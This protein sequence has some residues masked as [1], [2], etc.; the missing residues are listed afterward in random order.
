MHLEH[1]CNHVS[2]GIH[3]HIDFAFRVFFSA[4]IHRHNLGAGPKESELVPG[5]EMYL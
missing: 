2:K 3:D 4:S 5:R 1:L